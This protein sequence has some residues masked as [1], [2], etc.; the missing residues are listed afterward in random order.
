MCCISNEAREARGKLLHENPALDADTRMTGMPR[1]HMTHAIAR[2]VSRNRGLQLAYRPKE[3]FFMTAPIDSVADWLELPEIEFPV[4]QSPHDEGTVLTVLDVSFLAVDERDCSNL[5]ISAHK[6]RAG[7]ALLPTVTVDFA[8]QR[9]L[10]R[11]SVDL[12]DWAFVMST[13]TR[14]DHFPCTVEFGVLRGRT[15]AELL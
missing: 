1:L 9:T 14:A 15:Y 4:L 7:K 12:S 10:C 5:D 11:I 2:V 8:G 13:R 3:E 6:C